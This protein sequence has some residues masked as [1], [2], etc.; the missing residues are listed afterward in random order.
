MEDIVQEARISG[1]CFFL[2]EI[3]RFNKLQQ[4]T[5]LPHVEN[6]S[7]VLIGATTENPYHD[8]NPAIRS[9]CGEIYQL[10][11]LTKENLIELI[12]KALADERRGL[13]KYHFALTPSQIEQIAAAANGDARKALTLLESI[14]Y[15]SDE[16][17]GQTI[18]A[19]HVIEHLISRIGVYGDKKDHIFIIYYQPCKNL[20]VAVIPMLLCII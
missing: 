3:H 14:Y 12:E 8:V 17:D 10:K 13:G 1:K 5:L 11:R 9:R 7:I 19:D 6:G 2:D 18:A 16:V 20:C 15:A 4:D